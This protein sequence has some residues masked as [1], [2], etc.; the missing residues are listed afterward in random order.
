ME[1]E[2]EVPADRESESVWQTVRNDFADASGLRLLGVA[3]MLLWMAFQWGWGNDILL[4]PIVAR[5]FE[6]LDDGITWTS[7]IGS[8]AGATAVGSLFWGVTQTLDGVIVLSGLRLVPGVTARISR[9]LARQGLIKP[10]TELSFGTKFLVAY[11]SGA[12]LLCLIDV[13]ATGRPGLEARRRMLGQ[14]VALAVAGVAVAV[15]V[16]T[17]AAAVGRR[18]PATKG[19]A[20]VVV[21]YASNP[22]TW[23]VIY[24]SL[25]GLSALGSRLMVRFGKPPPAA[26]DTSD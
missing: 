10:F 16:V 7:A 3:G 12:S 8:T 25:V 17:G 26:V 15:V 4:P 24:G 14:A 20:D 1:L 23:L 9:L 13:F 19:A 2:E 22:V 11:A 18:V 21:R 5:T 6:A